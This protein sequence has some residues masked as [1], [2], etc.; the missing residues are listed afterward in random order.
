M[1]TTLF[2]F[3]SD[4]CTT[5]PIAL[6][7]ITKFAQISGYKLNLTKSVLFP[8]NDKARQMSFQDFPFSVSKDS[9]NYLGVCVT[10]KYRDPF[11]SNFKKMFNEAEQDMERWS[12]LPL[13]LAG[14]INSVK[15]T[16][17]PRFLF[18]FQAI[19]VFIPKSF[20]EDLN[21][22]I[23]TF[24]WNRKVTRIRKEYLERQKVDA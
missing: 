10:Y 9:F 12:T 4:P 7:L 1:Q 23:S 19:P 11:D 15:M 2:L 14:R 5:I 3:L 17:M 13:S 24:I 8:I 20:F 6:E 18:L 21:K 16:I 22:C